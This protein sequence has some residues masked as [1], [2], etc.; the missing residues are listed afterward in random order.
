[1]YFTERSCRESV[2]LARL[3]GRARPLALAALMKEYR[4]G[5]LAAVLS[6]LTSLCRDL[7]TSDQLSKPI[8]TDQEL[9][10]FATCLDGLVICCNNFEADPS[11]INQIIIFRQEILKHTVDRR[12]SVLHA[13]LKAILDGVEHNLDLRKF[14]YVPADQ[15]PYWNSFFWFGDEFLLTFRHAAKLE[16]QELGNCFAAGRWTACVL[17]SMRLAEHGLRKLAR[18]LRVTVSDKG[19]ICPIE[20]ADWNKVITGIRNKITKIRTLRAGSRKEQ[21]LQFYSEAADH[22]EYMKDIWRNEMAHTRRFYKKS[23][24]LGVINRVRDFT[25][26][27]AKHYAVAQTKRIQQLQS[28]NA[29]ITQSSP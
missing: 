5:D 20:F 18:T 12:E 19:K 13:R 8:C 11:L 15:A 25:Q 1:M 21:T 2:A 4:I 9:A 28:G 23:E 22:C 27:L 14:M 17:H 16:L 29:R 7:S 24:A 10:N 3:R 26:M 6:G